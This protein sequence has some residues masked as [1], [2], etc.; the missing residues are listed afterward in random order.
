MKLLKKALTTSLL[1]ASTSVLAEDSWFRVEVIIFA[2]QDPA[3]LSAEKWPEIHAIPESNRIAPL[4]QAPTAD[5]ASENIAPFSL[6]PKEQFNLTAER[7]QLQRSSQYR[8]LYHNGWYQPVA[9]TRKPKQIKINAGEILDNGM[10]ELEGYLAVGRGRYLHFRPDIYL[11]KTVNNADQGSTPL[12]ASTATP[13]TVNTTASAALSSASTAA[14]SLFPVVPEIL[15]VNLN[16][17][18]RMRSEELH[19]ID[20]PL[21]GILI[22]VLPLD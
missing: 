18:R 3:A 13:D 10:H 2:N 16:Q 12:T 9:Q 14:A 11:S 4:A 7:Q 5:T 15:T 22:E 19:Y 8:V 21:M 1:L 20:H 17:A 6:L